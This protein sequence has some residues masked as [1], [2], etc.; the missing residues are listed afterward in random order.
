MCMK[1]DSIQSISKL[2][3]VG[4][5]LHWFPATSLA[6]CLCTESSGNIKEKEHG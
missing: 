4:T 2:W 3:S 6:A 1:H 5:C